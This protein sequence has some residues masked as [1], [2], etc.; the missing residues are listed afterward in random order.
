MARL[1][2]IYMN[3][4]HCLFHFKI[5]VDKITPTNLILCCKNRE[6]AVF[7]SQSPGTNEGEREMAQAPSAALSRPLI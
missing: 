1:L 7:R 5:K 6:K 2:L 4:L 3:L